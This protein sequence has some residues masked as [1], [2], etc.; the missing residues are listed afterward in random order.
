MGKSK[1]LG[2]GAGNVVNGIIEQYYAATEDVKANTFVEYV[3][4]FELENPGEETLISS[5]KISTSVSAVQ[6]AENKVFVAFNIKNGYSYWSVYGVVCTINNGVVTAGT[7][8]AINT[9]EDATHTANNVVALALSSTKVVVVYSRD[10]SETL[11][12]VYGK[13]CLISGTTISVGAEKEIK[14]SETYWGYAKAV[15]LSNS[16]FIV[17]GESTGSTYRIYAVVCTVSGST[18]TTGTSKLIRDTSMGTDA[19][20][21][22]VKL[23]SN[24]ALLAYAR[25]SSSARQY[26]GTAVTILTISGTTITT[27]T[28]AFLE[29]D[30]TTNQIALVALSETKAI[31]CEYS[32]FQYAEVCTI[33]GTTVSIGTRVLADAT[34]CIK[35]MLKL[36]E[37]AIAFYESQPSGQSYTQAFLAR[38]DGT[39]ITIMSKRTAFLTIYQCSYTSMCYAY[40][41]CTSSLVMCVGSINNTGEMKAQLAN[42]ADYKGITPLTASAKFL[43]LT[44]TKATK[45]TQGKV[46]TLK[47]E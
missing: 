23:T 43:G 36:N 14:C 13:V 31:L 39:T 44:M 27:G 28:E 41:L 19:K 46:W 32:N 21:A 20:Y 12:S 9:V 5:Q 2:S 38:I 40:T 37:K 1:I 6:L 8:V 30:V 4:K 45:T 29:N 22:I 24:K 11:V 18:I 42:L 34:S 17:V 3:D 33:S 15:A 25:Y 35:N 26:Y 7:T 47:G 10:I 16:S